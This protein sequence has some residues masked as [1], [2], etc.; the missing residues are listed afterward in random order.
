MESDELYD[1]LDDDCPRDDPAKKHHERGRNNIK[2]LFDRKNLSRNSSDS[3][4]IEPLRLDTSRN[5]SGSD[6][7]DYS[8][9]ISSTYNGGMEF[10]DL[11]EVVPLYDGEK[12]KR[13]LNLKDKR[14][15]TYSNIFYKKIGKFKNDVEKSQQTETSRA[16]CGGNTER[17]D[18]SGVSSHF[19]DA[20]ST[21]SDTTSFY[22]DL[23]NKQKPLNQREF[24]PPAHEKVLKKIELDTQSVSDFNLKSISQCLV[25]NNSVADDTGK[26]TNRTSTHAAKFKPKMSIVAPPILGSLGPDMEAIQ[27]KLSLLKKRR[28]YGQRVSDRNRIKMKE[29]KV[30]KDLNEEIRKSRM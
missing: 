1:S 15:K 30:L 21:I 9:N 14:Q 6:R 5:A 17:S 11:S 26:T 23:L 24:K 7:G 20:K 2:V 16:Q 29:I 4:E 28:S 25:P 18:V 10:C 22:M 8:S 3:D 27:D 13:S 19:S 12:P